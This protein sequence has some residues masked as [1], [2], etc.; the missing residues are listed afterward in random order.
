MSAELYL[1]ADNA[2]TLGNHADFKKGT[3]HTRRTYS[4]HG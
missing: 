3:L 4:N 1:D 2:E